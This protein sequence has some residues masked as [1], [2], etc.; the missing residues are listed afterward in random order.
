MAKTKKN[1]S[2]KISNNKSGWICSGYGVAPSGE[3]CKGCID[4]GFG[5]KVMSM[6]QVKKNISSRTVR[7]SKGD[8]LDTVLKKIGNK[9]KK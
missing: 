4:C 2:K 8:N 5:K 1:K 6:Q 7:V 9:L 3:K